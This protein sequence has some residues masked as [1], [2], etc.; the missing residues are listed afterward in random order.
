MSIFKFLSAGPLKLSYC[1]ESIELLKGY[2]PAME[3][4]GSPLKLG[5]IDDKDPFNITGTDSIQ[6]YSKLRPKIK[7]KC[8]FKFY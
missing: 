8:F 7:S 3:K 4:L 5:K 1:K 6:V 2:R